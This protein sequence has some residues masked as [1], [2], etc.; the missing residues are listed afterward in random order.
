MTDAALDPSALLSKLAQLLPSERKTL[1]S[2]QEG[3]AALFHSA[4][5]A[6]GFRL[7]GIDDASTQGTFPDNVLPD[8]W[9]AHGPNNY[10]L[11]YRHEQSSLEFIIKVSKLGSR[12]IVNA[13]AVG[14]SKAIL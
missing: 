2:P 11:R 12:T 5:V 14:V 1:Q 8:D 9:S 4:L 6:L 7:V 10:T 13:I 3:V